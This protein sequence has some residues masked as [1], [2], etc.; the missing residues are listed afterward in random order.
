MSTAPLGAEQ[1]VTRLV[2]PLIVMLELPLFTVILPVEVHPKS[3]VTVT[4]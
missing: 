3:V 2:F 4:E 1:E